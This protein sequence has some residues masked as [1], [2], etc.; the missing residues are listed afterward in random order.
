MAVGGFAFPLP[1]PFFGAGPNGAPTAEAMGAAGRAGSS[2]WGSGAGWASS[3]SHSMTVAWEGDVGGGSS[4]HARDERVEPKTAESEPMRS[5][6]AWRIS[7]L[8][9]SLSEAVWKQSE[10]LLLRTLS[11]SLCGMGVI[12]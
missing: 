3:S 4:G 5:I 1:F 2:D 9:A 7:G 10:R 12:A 6:N 11:W 8:G